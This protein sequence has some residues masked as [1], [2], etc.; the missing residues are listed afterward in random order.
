MPENPPEQRYSTVNSKRQ[1]NGY[2]SHD[3]SK[4]KEGTSTIYTKV[5]AHKSE[6][7]SAYVPSLSPGNTARCGVNL[8]TG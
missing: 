2:E 4:E 6:S 8:E 1:G 3:D 5:A 7:R